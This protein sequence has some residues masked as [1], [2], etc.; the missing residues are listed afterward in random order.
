MDQPY[1]PPG[2][3]Q[4]APKPAFIDTLARSIRRA[5]ASGWPGMLAA[6]AVGALSAA[7]QVGIRALLAAEEQQWVSELSIQGATV[8]VNVL[9]LSAVLAWNLP[10]LEGSTEPFALVYG[11]LL[12]LRVWVVPLVALGL[13]LVLPGIAAAL[14]LAVAVPAVALRPGHRWG[15]EI[16]PSM[17]VLLLVGVPYALLWYPFLSVLSTYS[18]LGSVLAV[19]DALLV[20]FIFQ[21]LGAWL[22]ERPR[23]TPLPPPPWEAEA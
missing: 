11:R 15:Q 5:L 4:V 6:C 16:G 10:R 14:L 22:L 20:V 3:P 13:V 1:K 7:L 23:D 9:G 12:K 8:L 18:D 2:A 17:G 19:F 21:L